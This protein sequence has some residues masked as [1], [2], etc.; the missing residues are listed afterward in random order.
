MKPAEGTVLTV[1]RLAAERALKAAD[2]NNDPEYVLTEAIRVGYE[3]LEKTIDM[4]P[5]LKKAGVVDAGGKGYLIILE[6]MLRALQGL[7]LIHI[8]LR[9]TPPSD[10][11]TRP[12]F[13][14]RETSSPRETA[15][16]SMFTPP[17]TT[18]YG[19]VRSR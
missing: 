16:M 19:A 11:A 7:S 12:G 17:I 13:E 14:S 1:S 6:G 3:T 10:V 18:I 15:P 9:P 5:V 8:L 4:N 2:E